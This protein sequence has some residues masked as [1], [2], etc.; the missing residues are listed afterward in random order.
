MDIP[1]GSP[2]AHAFVTNIGLITSHGPHGHNIMAAEWT[3][4]VSYT[5][6]LIAVCIRASDA[7]HDNILATKE[8]GISLCA[9]DQNVLSSVAGTTKGKEVEKIK[10]LQALGHKFIMGKKIK[11]YLVD[12]AVLQLECKLV[13]HL[14][15]GSH[16]MFVGEVVE[17]KLDAGKQPLVYHS[18][19][20]WKLGEQIMKPPQSE[21]ENIQK[22]LMQHRKK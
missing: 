12:G 13:Q 2:E 18:G 1:W 5:P 15:L 17:K 22:T 6:A 7:T 16:T 14:A 20:Y 4:H 10:A 21:F 9:V 11:T 3:H 19:K 8:F